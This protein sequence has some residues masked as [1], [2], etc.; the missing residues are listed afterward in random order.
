[1][2]QFLTAAITSYSAKD[3]VGSIELSQKALDN[4][5][6]SAGA[7]VI[8]FLGH[9]DDGA[10]DQ[11][12]QFIRTF[13]AQHPASPNVILCLVMALLHGGDDAAR[14]IKFAKLWLKQLP[15]DDQRA[16]LHLNGDSELHVLR[17]AMLHSI[18]V[19]VGPTISG[20]FGLPSATKTL[21]PNTTGERWNQPS[22]CIVNDV[23]AVAGEW[24]LYDEKNV[25]LS[26]SLNWPQGFNKSRVFLPPLSATILS[27]TDTNALLN[28]PKKTTTI[29]EPCIFIG[30]HHNF[31]YWLTDHIARL[32]SIDGIFDFRTIPIVIE[33]GL[34]DTHKETLDALGVKSHRLIECAPG[35]TLF[36]K[37]AIVPTL[38]SSVD[39]LHPAA[40]QWLRKT[41]GP[42]GRDPAY[43]SRIFVSRSKPHRRRLLNESEVFEHLKKLG[44]VMVAPDSLSFT[45]QNHI[46]QNADI[47][48]GP[49]GTCLTGI[50]FAPETCKV[51]E[52]I[53]QVS[54]PLHRFIENIAVQIG[55]HFECVTT[56]V[57]RKENAVN[58][59]EYDFNADPEELVAQLAQHL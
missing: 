35:T 37:E 17:S 49:F 2:D 6:A 14:V 42:K 4:D 54:I 29:E 58:S 7:A 11:A 22:Y 52:I 23:S 9:W 31:Y 12:S 48:V 40:I 36:C 13:T 44:F 33:A 39:I 20:E 19:S 47:V 59:A 50:M 57:E 21:R 26:E 27:V 34:P 15:P 3:Y 28:V 45:E 25:Y 24:Y 5:P 43:P 56:D 8:H 53:D 18:A 32:Q 1:M 41:F 51:F 55:Q 46:F 16:D 10:R 38:L 30:G